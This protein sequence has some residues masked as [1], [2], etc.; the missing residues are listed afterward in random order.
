MITNNTD[1]SIQ[2]LRGLST[3]TKP[4]N[5][6]NGSEFREM[7]TGK[8]FMYD[9]ASGDWKEQPKKGGGAG[10]AF[11]LL[12]SGTFATGDSVTTMSIPVTYTG[13]PKLIMVIAK[14]VV[15]DTAQTVFG[16]LIT[17][18]PNNTL[19]FP[20]GYG[21][22]VSQN[23]YNNLIHNVIARNQNTFRIT[24]TTIIFGRPSVGYPWMPNTTFD[25]YIYG[26]E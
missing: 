10:S 22:Y 16:F 8:D 18:F 5:V 25:W 15:A 13:E 14:N 3:D 2:R 21:G 24:E 20:N 12:A 1:Y 6:P 11:K 4:V 7:D 23:T 9:E 17:E 26:N 19:E